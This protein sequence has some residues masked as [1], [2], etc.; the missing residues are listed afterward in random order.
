MPPSS[1]VCDAC[2]FPP[3][4]SVDFAGLDVPKLAYHL[5]DGCFGLVDFVVIR[6]IGDFVAGIPH[7][8]DVVT[9]FE[10]EASGG[11]EDEEL[12]KGLQRSPLLIFRKRTGQDAEVAV[13]Q[14]AFDGKP[15][16]GAQGGDEEEGGVPYPSPDDQLQRAAELRQAGKMD[17]GRHCEFFEGG[18]ERRRDV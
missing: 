10:I 13:S 16:R 7:L 3:V 17:V 6:L 15:W 12:R 4:A 2:P 18:D 8:G 14:Q 9:A 5:A 11:R 1:I